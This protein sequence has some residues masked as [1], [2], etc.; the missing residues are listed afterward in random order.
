MNWIKKGLIYSPDKSKVW[1]NSHCQLPVA[2]NIGDDFFRVYFASRTKYQRSHIGYFEID[3][4]N[5]VE[6]I[7][8]SESPILSP[9][10]IGYF[11]EHGVYPSS[12]VDFD[13]K[14]YMYFI[15]WNQGV[16]APLF[17]ASIGLAISSDGGVSF[18]RYSKAP[19]MSRSEH[20]PC[21]VTSPCVYIE[22]GLWRMTYVSGIKWEQV[23]DQLKSYYHI[24]YA[25]SKDGV[26][27]NRDGIIAVDF[28]SEKESNIARPTVVKENG[29]Y[30][31]WYSFVKGTNFYRIGYGESIDGKV[32]TRKDDEFGLDVSI[33]QFDSDMMCYPNVV[34]HKGIKYM[35]YNGNF[36]GK[37]GVGLAI[38]NN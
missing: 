29:L 6:I 15:G 18:K 13:N 20:D 34:L 7:A 35:F 32:F 16:N 12:I 38:L 17:Y 33:N 27:W 8:K 3:I 30:K 28:D 9:G 10:P 31:I 22:R 2:T 4:T 24:K 23:G 37:E 25:E 1:S 11:D 14:K 21:M 26:H 36:Y 19:I 5:P